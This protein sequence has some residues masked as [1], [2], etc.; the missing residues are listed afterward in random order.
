MAK[1]SNNSLKTIAMKKVTLT[2]FML[3]FLICSCKV[4]WSE[5]WELI[6]TNDT[7]HPIQIKQVHDGEHIVDIS[8]SKGATAAHWTSAEAGTDYVLGG[9]KN[10]TFVIYDDTIAI[11]HCPNDKYVIDDKPYYL[12]KNICYTYSYEITVTK[13]MKKLFK[14][15]DKHQYRAEYIF[16]EEDYQEALRIYWL[17]HPK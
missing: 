10:S 7:E 11:Q 17:E 5:D 12:K 9:W 16:T 6:F 1:Y 15:P 4:E 13:T 8:L 3:L 14:S 2:V